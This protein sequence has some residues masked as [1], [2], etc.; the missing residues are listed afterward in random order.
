MLIKKRSV[1]KRGLAFSSISYQFSLTYLLRCNIEKIRNLF[2]SYTAWKKLFV[3]NDTRTEW[4]I[5]QTFHREFPS[6]KHL[7]PA[8]RHVPTSGSVSLQQKIRQFP[9]RFKQSKAPIDYVSIT[10]GII[11]RNEHNF[12]ACENSTANKAQHELPMKDLTL[13]GQEF[14]L[15]CKNS[16]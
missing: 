12:C 4:S 11:W 1:S 3:N 15:F 6:V 2:R 9:L 16:F 7:T 14:G 5:F 8:Q 13:K 10:F